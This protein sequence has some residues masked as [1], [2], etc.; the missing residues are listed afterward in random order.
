MKGLRSISIL[1]SLVLFGAA[2]AYS[3]A[4]NGSLQGTVTDAS[5][6][7]IAGAK[8][9]LTETNT[10]IVKTSE[11]NPS[12]NYEFPVIP[13]GTYS[14]AVEMAGFK[15]EVRSGIIVE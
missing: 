1:A 9:T 5:G 7:S 6:G 14:V 10:L 13:P 2:A 4:V 12:G 3:Q 11:P 8:G 15:K